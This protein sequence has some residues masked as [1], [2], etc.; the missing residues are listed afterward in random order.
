MHNTIA[1]V[2]LAITASSEGSQP[3][4][5]VNEVALFNKE[6]IKEIKLGTIDINN[7]RLEI[8]SIKVTDPERVSGH[9]SLRSEIYH[10]Y[11]SK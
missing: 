5:G 1:I 9:K 2:S 3:K 11:Y 7:I 4:E 8:P 6:Q 10:R